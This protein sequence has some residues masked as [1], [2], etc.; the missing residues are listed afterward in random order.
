MSDKVIVFNDNSNKS[1]YLLDYLVNEGYNPE[2]KDVNVASTLEDRFEPITPSG[3]KVFLP[4]S[5]EDLKDNNE[6][7]RGVIQ[8][9]ESK[10]WRNLIVLPFEGMTDASIEKKVKELGLKPS[11]K[12]E[13]LHIESLAPGKLVPL[14][15]RN[16]GSEKVRIDPDSEMKEIREEMDPEFDFD[17]DKDL[18]ENIKDLG[19]I[20]PNY[21]NSKTYTITDDEV[22][23]VKND[24]KKGRERKVSDVQEEG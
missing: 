3:M 19:H 18:Q 12:K 16:A 4:Y 22:K 14:Q 17:P 21:P 10:G 23:E 20:G 24:T 5:F 8:G 15:V 9:L 1:I 2:V 7:L 6:H 13:V 11:S